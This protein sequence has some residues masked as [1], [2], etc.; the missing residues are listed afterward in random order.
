[1]KEQLGD[2]ELLPGHALLEEGSQVLAATVQ[3]MVTQNQYS[4]RINSTA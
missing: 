3:S 4:I 2:S 1:M